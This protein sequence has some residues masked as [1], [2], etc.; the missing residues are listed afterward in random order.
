M[1]R[2]HRSYGNLA[3]WRFVETGPDDVMM[4]TD[5]RRAVASAL[6]VAVICLGGA[7]FAI[8]MTDQASRWWVVFWSA[9]IVAVGVPGWILGEMMAE[10]K[11]GCLLRYAGRD[12]VLELPRLGKVVDSARSRVRFSREHYS[13]GS[14]HFFEFN[15]VIDGH[16]LPFL[17]S[18][19]LNAFKRAADGLE[20]LGFPVEDHRLSL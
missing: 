2:L 12:D 20:S 5:P 17:S 3:T 11:K 7:V 8:G 4:T 13:D 14:E 10:R 15:V 16:R 18:S 1:E 9:L 6:L 19:E